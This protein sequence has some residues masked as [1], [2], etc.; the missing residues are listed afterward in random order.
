MEKSA[1]KQ[2][3]HFLWE[4][5]SVWSWVIDFILAFLLVRF[6]VY[7]L[8]GLILSTSL[9][10]VVV[11]SGSMEHHGS[12]EDWWGRFGEWYE[13]NNM[14]RE[15]LK[16]WS[17]P[18]GFNTGDIMITKGMGEYANYNV[19][20]VLIFKIP[21]QNTPIIHRAIK[22]NPN[23]YAFETKGDNNPDQAPYEKDVR[24]KQVISKAA[25]RIPYLGWIKLFFVK[26][27]RGQF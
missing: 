18:D 25:Y 17:F 19:G 9:P 13:K 6:I 23:F 8:L 27:I 7:P 10:L 16:S 20:D 3:W 24:E 2:V 1:V 14:T 5:D 21:S 4:S 11:E 12:F 26:L 22:K 15:D